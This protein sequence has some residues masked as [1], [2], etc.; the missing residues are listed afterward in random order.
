VGT[1]PAASIAVSDF[2]E[3][4]RDQ[5]QSLGV[6]DVVDSVMTYAGAALSFPG[7]DEAGGAV[8]LLGTAIDA[9]GFASGLAGM[10]GAFMEGGQGL[11]DDGFYDG[12]GAVVNNG[13]SLGLTGLAA[14][15]TAAGAGAG[16]L[17]G[18]I[19]GPI[20]TGLGSALGLGGATAVAGAIEGLNST[21]GMGMAAA[22][23]LGQGAGAIGGADAE[24]SADSITGGLIRGG[25]GDESMGWSIGSAVSGALGGGTG[26]DVV[27]GLV[28]SAANV[29]LMPLNFLDTAIGGAT[30]FVGDLVDGND[31]EDDRWQTFKDSINPFAGM[32]D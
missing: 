13:L 19:F 2:E 32:Y 30:N 6:M 7:V 27:G 8:P 21:I 25:W 5:Q 24:F 9:Y 26:A 3:K 23:M 18:S 20:G 16:G 22:D 14:G 1:R 12:A 4:P 11:H 28:G 10:G 31:Q 29:P 15:V 17:V